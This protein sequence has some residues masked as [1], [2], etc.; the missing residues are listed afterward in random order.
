[1]YSDNNINIESFSVLSN[2][3]HRIWKVLIAKFERSDKQQKQS[4]TKP[5]AVVRRKQIVAQENLD[6]L[7]FLKF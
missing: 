3:T 7:V 5:V 1:M 2:I 6:I 4:I